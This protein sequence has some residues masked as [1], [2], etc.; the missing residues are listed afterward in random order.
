MSVQILFISFW[1]HGI[2]HD[3]KDT[4][5]GVHVSPGSAATLVRRGGITNQHLIA[6]SLSNISAKNSWNWLICV[7]V[8]LCYISVIFW[9]TV[10]GQ[11]AYCTLRLYG[12]RGKNRYPAI[13]TDADAVSVVITPGAAPRFWKWGGDKF[14]PPLFGQCGGQNIA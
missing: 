7:G 14:W 8:I 12:H 2:Q 13:T 5:S 10:Y 6:Y 9:D 11:L 3:W 4:I 1:R